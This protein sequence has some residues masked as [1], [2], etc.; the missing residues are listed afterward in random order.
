VRSTS[1]VAWPAG[2]V[3]L[4]IVLGATA[5]SAANPP[6]RRLDSEGIPVLS[7]LR[8]AGAIV[9]DGRLTESVWTNAEALGQ[10]KQRDPNE[11]QPETERTEIRIAFDDD[12]LYVGARMSDREPGRIVRQLSR[13]D[14]DADCDTITIY[15]DPQH[16]HRTGVSLRVSAAGSLADALIY[17][18]NNQDSAWDGVWD[19]AVTTDEQGWTAELR[20]P[21]SQLRFTPGPRQTWGLNARRHIQR[22]NEDTWWVLVPKTESRLASGMG[23]LAGLNDVPPKRHLDLLPYA[24]TGLDVSGTLD[25]ANPLRD[26]TSAL[27]GIGLDAKWGLTSSLTLDATVNPD[28]GQVEVDPA[29]VNLTAF[30]TFYEEKRPFFIEGAQLYGNFGKNGLLLYGRFGA[31]YPNLYYSR[32]IG[33]SPQLSVD[34]EFVDTPAATTILAAA[35]LAGRL[36]SGWNVAFLDALTGREYA[37]VASGLERSTPETEPLTNYIAARA[38]RDFGRRGSVGLLATSV[39]RDFRTTATQAYLPGD[40]TVVGVDGNVFLDQKRTWVASG[41][42]AGS[43]VSGSLRRASNRWRTSS[44]RPC[45][46]MFSRARART[47]QSG[48]VTRVSHT[49]TARGSSR[50]RESSFAGPAIARS[51]EWASWRRAGTKPGFPFTTVSSARSRIHTN[52]PSKACRNRGARMSAG[53]RA[54]SDRAPLRTESWPSARS[55]RISRVWSPCAFGRRR[56]REAKAAVLSSEI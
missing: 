4:S 46:P 9:I 48:S 5:A 50:R 55:E 6:L 29:V 23:H 22:S 17:D 38:T 11:G 18:D 20:V 35:K 32:R 33:R 12:A 24:R 14:S 3:C 19:A 16:D 26:T 56:S 7:P 10:L 49:E 39:V 51:G 31:R 27:G 36:T 13:R 45:R 2:C 1:I 28:F 53:I 34:G 47:H 41:S 40:A 8:T 25:P 44:P 52:V 37:H 43:A 42:F 15:L 30:E 21:F 54:T